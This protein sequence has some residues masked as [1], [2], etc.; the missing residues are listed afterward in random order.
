MG[1]AA[2]FFDLDRTLLKGA[3]GP[4]FAE[5]LA[6][7]GVP[8]ARLPLQGVFYRTYDLVGETI[9]SALLTRAAALASRG[10]AAAD[11]R[12]AGR[13]AAPRLERLLRPYAVPLLEEH[14]R[15]A[16]V[17]V[18]ATTSPRDLVAPLA[19][20]L[21]MDG[22]VAT[23]YQ[24]TDGVYT[25]ALEGEFV[26]GPGKLA[27]V[28][29]W[30]AGQD[31]SLADSFGYSDSFFDVPLLSALGRPFA[32]N[33]DPRLRVAAVLARWP[34]LD[35]DVPPGV[36]TLAGIEPA[37]LLQIV[38]PEMFP[39]ARFDIGPVEGV[40]VSG[41][42]IVVANHRSYFDVVA[43]GLTLLRRKRPVRFLAK[44]EIFD[45]PVV[46]SVARAL[47]GIPVDRGSASENPLREAERMLE[48][49]EMVVVLPQ[50][51]IPRGDA[52]FE[53]QLVGKTGAARLAASSGAPVVPVGLWGT[54]QVWHRNAR[55]PNVANV[56]HPPEVRVR[57]GRPVSLA[58]EDPYDDTRRIMEAIMDLLPEEARRAHEPTAEEI[59]LTLPPDG[60]PPA[61]RG[62]S[63]DG[64]GHRGASSTG[65]RRAGADE[66]GTGRRRPGR[67]GAGS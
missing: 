19:E 24:E 29:R 18:M 6:G 61:R 51:T 35:L 56:L 66:R 11:A 36:P 40:P 33:P 63:R 26:W 54:E 17:L 3:S 37:D 55:V 60:A 27:A 43:L 5:A 28:R 58:Y 32:V 39:F 47:G 20:R 38:R 13:A 23:R 53:P 9:F 45:A 31:V 22:L 57:V 16:R 34:V 46:G 62:G 41:P 21:G 59:A 15:A 42:V 4:V 14:R 44:R 25:G 48:A 65:P 67:P 30:A 2:A 7:V 1:R 12:E 64:R 50:G 8:G 10:V 52:F 49:N